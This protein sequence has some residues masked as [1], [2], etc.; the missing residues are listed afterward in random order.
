MIALITFLVIATAYGIYLLVE[1]IKKS[2]EV[3][4]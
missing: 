2:N 3:K 1:D 4:R